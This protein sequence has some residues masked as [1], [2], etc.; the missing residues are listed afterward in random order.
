M[1]KLEA[2]PLTFITSFIFFASGSL[3]RTNYE[4]DSDVVALLPFS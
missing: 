4:L 1:Y 2:F 3:A